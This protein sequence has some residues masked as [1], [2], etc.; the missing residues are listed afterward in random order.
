MRDTFRPLARLVCSFGA[1]LI[2]VVTAGC[3]GGGGSGGPPPPPAMPAP[4]GFSYPRPQIYPVGTAIAAL[5]PAITGVVTSYSASPAL[6]A[7]LVIDAHTGIITGTPTIAQPSAG[8]MITAA[9]TGGSAIFTVSI[10]IP[11]VTA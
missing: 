1:A 4:T 7:G 3:G 5:S 9:N 11:T 10:A 8:Y 2:L 6:P